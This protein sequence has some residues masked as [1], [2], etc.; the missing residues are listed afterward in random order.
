M[1]S[2]LPALAAA[3]EA[4]SE[5]HSQ[6]ALTFFLLHFTPSQ[7]PLQGSFDVALTYGGPSVAVWGWIGVSLCVLCVSLNMAELSSAVSA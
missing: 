3:A 2:Q 7:H 4:A 5:S 1:Y 6:P